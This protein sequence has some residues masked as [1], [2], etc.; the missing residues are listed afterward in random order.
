MKISV[1]MVI[2]FRISGL[3]FDTRAETVSELVVCLGESSRADNVKDV[4]LRCCFVSYG[5]DTK[6][7]RK[8]GKKVRNGVVHRVRELE[9]DLKGF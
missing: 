2:L 8:A 5:K 1:D 7:V 9:R 6:I 4:A 3:D